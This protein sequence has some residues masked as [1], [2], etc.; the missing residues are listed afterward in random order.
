MNVL[1]TSS[2]ISVIGNVHFDELPVHLTEV[3]MQNE[4]L[5]QASVALETSRSHYADLYDFAPVAY[6]TLSAEGLIAEINLTGAKLLGV[7]RKKLINRR[8]AQFIVD[9]D[10]D[11]WHRFCLL[12]RQ[13]DGKQSCEL[14]LIPADGIPLIACLNCTRKLELDGS[15]Q[16]RIAINDITGQKQAEAEL[17]ITAAAIDA[18]T[19]L[20]VTDARKII[21][22]VNQAFTRITGYSAEEAIGQTPAFLRSDWHDEGFYYDLWATVKADGY[23]QGEV[24]NKHKNG[25]IVPAWLS[26]AMVT[27]ANGGIMHF[28]G[29]F[30]DISL[31]KQ[32]EQVLL[33]ARQHLESQVTVTKE[34]LDKVKEETAGINI[35]LNVLLNHR[36]TDKS[37]AQ[38]AL[39]QE[40]KENILP[41]LKKL[42]GTSAGRIQTTRLIDILETNLMDLVKDYGTTA[43]HLSAIYKQLT[44][45][46]RQVASMIRQGLGTKVIATTLNCSSGTVGVHRKHIRKKLGL[47]NKASNLHSYLQSLGE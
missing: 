42:K 26:I 47:D 34:E 1:G 14:T 22:R 38:I 28:V 11:T 24:W 8:F 15:P 20:I 23:W 36:T 25:Q 4:E 16:L 32:A 12:A 18:Q 44:P 2:E 9:E 33:E 43:N 31:Y 19:G 41:F 7:E 35:A 29:S 17:R 21:L 27:N 37:D 30:T 3:D 39:S 46:E 13:H 40:V 6:L 45:I 5:R 10:K